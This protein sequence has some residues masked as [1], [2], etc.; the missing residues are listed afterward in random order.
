MKVVAKM[1]VGSQNYHLDVPESDRDYKFLLLP[2]FNDLYNYHKVNKHD[3]PANYD[4]EHYGVMSVM[5]FDENLRKG[6]VNVLEMLFSKETDIYDEKLVKYFGVAREAF[7]SGYLGLVWTEFMRTVHG[8]MENS[9]D[10]YGVTKKTASRALWLLH[11]AENTARRNFV[12]DYQNYNDE[13]VWGLP[14]QLRL[15]NNLI[16]TK[17]DLNAYY[18][19]LLKETKELH[20]K[21]QDEMVNFNNWDNVLY[22]TMREYVFSCLMGES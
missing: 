5:K 1:L 13:K 19:K 17:E 21:W 2:E 12:V 7:N 18:D 16:F 10:R 22:T 9:V 6:N 11:F 14:R 4:P 3:L 20:K 15:S 8:M